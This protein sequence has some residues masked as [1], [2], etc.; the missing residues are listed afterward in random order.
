ML[1]AWTTN[2]RL[3][4]FATS[5]STSPD[6]RRTSRVAVSYRTETRLRS[7]NV[8]R[9]PSARGTC[10]ISPIAVAGLLRTYPC[11]AQNAV[12]KPRRT[13]AAD[14][15]GIA[16]RQNLAL[17][18]SRSSCDPRNACARSACTQVACARASAPARRLS[19]ASHSS[20]TACSTSVKPRST[21]TTQAD[22]AASI[23][24]AV[25]RTVL[26]LALDGSE[27]H[28]VLPAL[29]VQL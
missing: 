8:M 22:A 19:P 12:A 26:A 13:V 17:G 5:N 21:R 27:L 24:C 29:L 2:G 20:S 10:R 15:H 11:Q 28:I 1:P 7:S 9:D 23:A 16:L 18:D 14:A 3:G 6:S 25:S 4:S